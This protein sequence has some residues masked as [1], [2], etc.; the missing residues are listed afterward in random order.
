MDLSLL[1]SNHICQTLV[2][3]TLS[4]LAPDTLTIAILASVYLVVLACRA[5]VV[6]QFV[7]DNKLTV[8]N[9]TLALHLTLAYN[10][11]RVE[12]LPPFATIVLQP[13]IHSQL[14]SLLSCSTILRTYLIALALDSQLC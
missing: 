13:L 2:P 14:P 6:H 3:D 1:S 5:I 7:P 4:L 10:R 11:A 8:G 12:S 9:L